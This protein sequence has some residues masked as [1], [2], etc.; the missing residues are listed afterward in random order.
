MTSENDVD[1]LE[2][3]TGFFITMRAVYYDFYTDDFVLIM[4]PT[5]RIAEIGVRKPRLE[6][7]GVRRKYVPYILAV[8]TE[9]EVGQAALVPVRFKAV[10]MHAS[11]RVV[12]EVTIENGAPMTG[13]QR[14]LVNRAL[15]PM[16]LCRA[17][18]GAASMQLIGK[19]TLPDQ[20]AMDDVDD[21]ARDIV[22]NNATHLIYIELTMG[23]P[24]RQVVSSSTNVI[25]DINEDNITRSFL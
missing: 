17:Y 2:G 1:H 24:P 8:F 10:P 13:P 4:P 18:S 14:G 3:S 5:A 11:D 23:E 22:K 19:L 21:R 6:R 12:S 25:S 20:L 16:L 7:K 15:R 9:I